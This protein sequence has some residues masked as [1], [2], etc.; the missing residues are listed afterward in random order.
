MPTVL[1]V[2]PGLGQQDRGSEAGCQAVCTCRSQGLGERVCTDA[3]PAHDL[4]LSL[5]EGT[6]WLS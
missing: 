4:D 3:A 5:G 1:G 2:G 6:W